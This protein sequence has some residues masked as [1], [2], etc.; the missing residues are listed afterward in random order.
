[1][2]RY[3]VV[4]DVLLYV[5][6]MCVI[7]KAVKTAEIKALPVRVVQVAVAVLVVVEC[8]IT[9][10]PMTLLGFKMLDTGAAPMCYTGHKY[11]ADEDMYYGDYL[12][13]NTQYMYIDRAYDAI[14]A[15]AGYDASWDILLPSSNG[16]ALSGNM[17]RLN[18]DSKRQKRVFYTNENTAEMKWFIEGSAAL[19]KEAGSLRG[20]A[21]L[22]V[23]PYYRGV[24]NEG[25][26]AE[27]LKYYDC[28]QQGTYSSLQGEIYYYV[29]EKK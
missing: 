28:V 20:K 10:D 22:V 11:L 14:L 2:A 16:N 12:V 27:A 25:M 21:I 24:D 18:W 9:I 4:G 7:E 17:Y 3:N 29:M 19:A 5:I 15:E 26:I 23:N 8:F 1:M 6:A 13:Y